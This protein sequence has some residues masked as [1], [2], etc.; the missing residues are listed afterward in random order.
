[1][2]QRRHTPEQVIRKL[3]DGEKLLNQGGD[4]KANDAKRLKELEREN[5]RLKRI[6]ANQALDNDMLRYIA[7]GKEPP[8]FPLHG[9]PRTIAGQVGTLA[10]A[11]LTALIDESSPRAFR[12]T[13]SGRAR[14]E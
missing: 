2:K 9:A 10:D 8:V 3:A 14:Q 11:N 6:V 12:P 1:M 5:V 4:M 13:N 7:E